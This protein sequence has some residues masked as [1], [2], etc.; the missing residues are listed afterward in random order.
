M[1]IIT[2]KKRITIEQANVLLEMYY[3]GKTSTADEKLLHEFLSQESI[4]EYLEAD[5]ALFGYFANKKQKPKVLLISFLKWSSVAAVFFGLMLF[6]K[7]LLNDKKSNF[8]YINGHKYTDTQVVKDQALAS[9]EIMSS[10]CDEIQESSSNL[11][12]HDLIQTQLQLFS[13]D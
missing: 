6:S 5:R 8:T 12:D 1:K 10:S 7:S 13:E 4:P 9:L 3:E 11:N 2:L